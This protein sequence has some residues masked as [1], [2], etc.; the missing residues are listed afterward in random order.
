MPRAYVGD[1]KLFRSAAYEDLAPADVKP[2][3]RGAQGLRKKDL[4]K[5]GSKSE[6]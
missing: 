2:R 3:N 5:K 4:A 6:S 1:V